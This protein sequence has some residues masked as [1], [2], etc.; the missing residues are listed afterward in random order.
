MRAIY[1]PHW[2]DVIRQDKEITK[3]IMQNVVPQLSCMVNGDLD[4]IDSKCD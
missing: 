3:H 4:D 2:F 1:T